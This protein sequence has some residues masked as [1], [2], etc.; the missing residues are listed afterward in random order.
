MEWVSC[1]LLA[2][3]DSSLAS[4]PSAV[5]R[6]GGESAAIIYVDTNVCIYQTLDARDAPTVVLE[7]FWMDRLPDMESNGGCTE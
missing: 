2:G 4:V 3:D 6:D 7:L 1:R 5:P